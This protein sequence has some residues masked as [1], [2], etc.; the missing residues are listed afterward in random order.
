M[1]AQN[2]VIALGLEHVSCDFCGAKPGS[3][4][5]SRRSRIEYPPSFIHNDRWYASRDQTHQWDEAKQ[6]YTPKLSLISS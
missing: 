5:R 1:S 6:A 4:C 3:R 2:T